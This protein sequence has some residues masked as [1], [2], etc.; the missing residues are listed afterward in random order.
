M[1]YCFAHSN[2][3]V[4]LVDGTITT[5]ENLPP[6]T[7]TFIKEI[8]RAIERSGNHSLDAHRSVQTKAR[9]T[10]IKAHQKDTQRNANSS[11]KNAGGSQDSP[12]LPR[13]AEVVS[14]DKVK[15]NAQTANN[16]NKE[17]T[18]DQPSL[19]EPRATK[20]QFKWVVDQLRNG[21]PA[22]VAQAKA[23]TAE[24]LQGVIAALTEV[25]TLDA[26]DQ[27]LE[28]I[29]NFGEFKRRA[30]A[31]LKS[32]RG[33]V[34]ERKGNAQSTLSGKLGDPIFKDRIDGSKED[35]SLLE[36]MYD[37]AEQAGRI[38]PESPR[39]KVVGSTVQVP[40]LA[41]IN[42]LAARFNKRV[43]WV[44]GLGADG[45]AYGNTL[46]LDPDSGRHTQ[47][48]AAHE[49]AHTLASNNRQVFQKL[50]DTVRPLISDHWS[51]FVTDERK[52]SPNISEKD[53]REEY[54]VRLISDFAYRATTDRVRNMDYSRGVD[55]IGYNHAYLKPNSEEKV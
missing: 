8:A 52:A 34:K 4:E 19:Q 1:V 50:I 42:E 25:R 6:K 35:Q 45:V 39:G 16:P 9:I 47:V 49:I 18:N 46:F 53:L 29:T 14:K 3:I 32:L 17:I 48:L 51:K 54:A 41:R 31:A 22:L 26:N 55:F 20:K 11:G 13:S 15:N 33:G 27:R 37:A 21:V 38:K 10:G 43:V 24:R 2:A 7:H 12:G 40:Q 5:F 44:E 23:L 30:E 36:R 28:K